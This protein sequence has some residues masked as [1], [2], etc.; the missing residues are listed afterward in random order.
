MDSCPAYLVKVKPLE[1]R[2]I[3]GDSP[4]TVPQKADGEYPE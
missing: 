4:V 3:E 2:T 1:S